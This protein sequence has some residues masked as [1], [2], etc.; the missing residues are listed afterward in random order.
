RAGLP[1]VS[2]IILE[3]RQLY[4]RGYHRRAVVG[5]LQCRHIEIVFA[6]GSAEAFGLYSLEHIPVPRLRQPRA[7][8]RR[9]DITAARDSVPIIEYIFVKSILLF[10]VILNL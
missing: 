7:G 6:S 5:K 4:G 1:L 8:R 10:P 9:A 3:L 2:V